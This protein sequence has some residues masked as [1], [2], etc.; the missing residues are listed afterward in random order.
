MRFL[1]KDSYCLLCM[2]IWNTGF[3]FLQNP[4]SQLPVGV[5]ERAQELFAVLFMYVVDMLIWAEDKELP[6]GL[7]PRYAKGSVYFMLNMLMNNWKYQNM[8]IASKSGHQ[9][10][11]AYSAIHHDHMMIHFNSILLLFPHK[12][13]ALLIS[14]NLLI[15]FEWTQWQSFGAEDFKDS[16]P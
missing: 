2:F 4:A 15:C 6:P 1:Y 12:P 9:A 3:V 7:Q 13:A 10:I 14:R 8:R 16:S 11:W 5:A